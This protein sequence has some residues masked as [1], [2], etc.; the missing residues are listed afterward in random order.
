MTSNNCLYWV[1]CFQVTHHMQYPPK[2]SVVYSYF[3]SRGGKF[4]E[5]LFFGLQYIL[6]RWLVGSVVTSKNIEEA[7][8]VYH[9][10]FGQDYFNADGWRYI[11]EVRL[12]IVI[13]IVT[14]IIVVCHL[15]HISFCHIVQPVGC[16]IISL[17]SPPS[18]FVDGHVWTIWF[19]VCWWPQSQR[20][21]VT[22][23]HLCA[24]KDD[25]ALGLCKWFS[26]PCVVK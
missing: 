25:M 6:K 13:I 8:D 21:D 22:R 2:T 9:S 7:K 17:M 12:I 26:S 3:E 20:S 16:V 5:I 1:C 19:I 4:D 10:H 14:V 15:L 23:S 18:N 11:V 24:N